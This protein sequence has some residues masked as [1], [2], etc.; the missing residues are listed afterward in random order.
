MRSQRR[1][2]LGLN[3]F[4]LGLKVLKIGNKTNVS[5]LFVIMNTLMDAKLFLVQ[6]ALRVLWRTRNLQKTKGCGKKAVLVLK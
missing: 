6:M 4:D 2:N 5:N 3:N 1:P